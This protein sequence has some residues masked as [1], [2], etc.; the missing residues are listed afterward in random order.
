[1]SP[2]TTS[3]ERSSHFTV[4]WSR[5]RRYIGST[6]PPFWHR[7]DSARWS[8]DSWVVNRDAE[9]EAK[10]EAMRVLPETAEPRE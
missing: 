4:D 8:G 1:M 10:M 6:K 7:S 2:L 9:L 5:I 3:A